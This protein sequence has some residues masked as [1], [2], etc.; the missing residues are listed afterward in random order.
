ML[1]PGESADQK[2]RAAR[3]ANALQR[4]GGA[5]LFGLLLGGRAVVLNA[6]RCYWL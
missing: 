6:T 3:D 4:V 1:S 2:P 5:L